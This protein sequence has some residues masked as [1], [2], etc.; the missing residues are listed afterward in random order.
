[1]KSKIVCALLL[2]VGLQLKAQKW[3]DTAYQTIQISNIVYGT[4]IDFGGQNRLLRM[5]VSIPANDTPPT[6]G[7]PLLIAIHGG[8]FMGGSKSTGAPPFLMKE[9]AQR[10]YVTAS[11]NYRL[12]MFQTASA[13]N[14]NI[15]NWNCLNM[16]DTAEW[17][18][19]VYRGMQ[20]AK[21]A[22]RFLLNQ[23]DSLKIDPKN[24]FVVGESAGG[25]IALATAFIDDTLEKHPSC[26]AIN[27][28]ARPNAIYESPCL[29]STGHTTSLSAL[30]LS[31][32]DLG[33]IDGDLNPT[34]VNY[35]IKGVGSIYGAIT[36]DY[37]SKYAYSKSPVIYAYH[38]PN[39]LIVPYKQQRIFH[40]YNICAQGFPANCQSIVSRPY[41]YGSSGV[42]NLIKKLKPTVP[43][44]PD[45]LFDS[46]LNTANCAMQVSNPA[47]TGHAIDQGKLRSKNMANFFSKQIDTSSANCLPSAIQT[48]EQ[49]SIFRVFPNPSS[50]IV[51]IQV[52]ANINQWTIQLKEMSGKTL[53]TAVNQNVIEMSEYKSGL[54]MI[55]LSADNIQQ[56]IKFQFIK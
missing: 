52:N 38:Q 47:L 48:V 10:G 20:D 13:I 3:V 11:I 33:S 28:V 19:A 40:D 37:F 56:T 25:F 12:G 46:T 15:P 55:V 5:D 21:G 53:K 39:D 31:R 24:V 27:T 7:R 1:M 51:N 9:F 16:A 54:Y 17:Y 6:C 26:Y 23:K 18:R 49:K 44:L 43:Q 45:Y 35:T 2:I 32:P 42:F 30:N 22:I 29:V 4:A 34:S 50:G 8:A 41:V 36:Y 14:C